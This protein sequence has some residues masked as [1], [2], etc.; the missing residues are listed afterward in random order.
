[1]QPDFTGESSTL[2]NIYF[3][4]QFQSVAIRET[5]LVATIT[6]HWTCLHAQSGMDYTWA[7]NTFCSVCFAYKCINWQCDRQCLH[8]HVGEHVGLTWGELFLHR[9]LIWRYMLVIKMKERTEKHNMECHKALC[10]V[11]CCCSR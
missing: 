7:N 6:K 8:M 9:Q 10:W 3:V 1:M 5:F 2:G 4:K 11:L